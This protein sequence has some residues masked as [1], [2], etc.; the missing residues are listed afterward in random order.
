MRGLKS[1]ARAQKTAAVKADWVEALAA[2]KPGPIKK[3]I[4][5]EM[6]AND[7]AT[8]AQ[9]ASVN[10]WTIDETVNFLFYKFCELPEWHNQ[11]F[12]S[13]SWNDA[14]ERELKE[15]KAVRAEK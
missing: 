14:V 2:S 13:E 11:G 6:P 3:S 5:I 8:L 10:G 4:V 7:W 9:G 12:D 1:K 15:H